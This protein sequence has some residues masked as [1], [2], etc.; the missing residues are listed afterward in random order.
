LIRVV[1]VARTPLA[2]AGLRAVLET[3]PRFRVTDEAAD[4]AT[5]VS[6]S[7]DDADV[8]L[9]DGRGLNLRDLSSDDTELIPGV[10]LLGRDDALAHVFGARGGAFGHLSQDAS[11][12]QVQ[13]A[14]A[15][16]AA[17]LSVEEPALEDGPSIHAT[18]VAETESP[19]LTPREREVLNLV[20]L[21]LTNK[22]IALR[23]GISD[24]TVK[25]HLASV[26][27]KLAASS[28]AE[29]IARAAHL[30]II[31]L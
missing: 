19:P 22:G 14:I 16:V 23:L 8:A 27:T 6:R 10:V 2:R 30:G 20:A 18:E 31:S 3:D 26:L 9:I 24:H 1:L 21:G 4:L 25:F 15:A 5:I 7:W 29:A 12:P 17:G 11:G 28:R 13:A